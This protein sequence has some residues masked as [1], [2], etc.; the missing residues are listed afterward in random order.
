MHWVTAKKIIDNHL[1][2]NNKDISPQYRNR[3]VR[4]GLKIGIE[5]EHESYIMYLRFLDP[6][7][8]NNKYCWALYE[9]YGLIASIMFIT[10]WSQKSFERRGG[11][12]AETIPIDKFKAGN[13]IK[14][15][16]YCE[17]VRHLLCERLVIVDKKSLKGCEV[18]NRKGRVDPRFG[19]KLE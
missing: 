4:P 2:Y 15:R 3:P 7:H 6:F 17:Y 8:S 5:H 11:V 16:E 13:L 10:R 18:Y 1:Y 9:K 19:G 14:Y 12:V